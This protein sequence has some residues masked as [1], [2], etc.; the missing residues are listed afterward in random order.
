M[1][2]RKKIPGFTLAEVM[3]ALTLAVVVL[4]AALSVYIQNLRGLH[5]AEQRMKLASQ[6][7]KFTDELAVHSTRSNAFVLFKTA[8]PADFDGPNAVATSGNQDRQSIFGALRPGGDFI[9]F[10]YYQ[11]PKAVRTEAYY[12]VTKLEGYFLVPDPTT[13]IGTVRKVVIDLSAA[14][15]LPTTAALSK[16][17][18]ED[19]LTANWS[20]TFTNHTT[21]SVVTTYTRLFTYSRGLL[22][23]EHVDNAAVVAPGTARLFYMSNANNV[24]ISGQIYS[25]GDKYSGITGDWRTVTQSFNFTITPRT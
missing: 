18:V 8:T 12:R 25:T 2:L 24:I 19:I 22:V 5:T 17:A 7:K 23:P 3:V 6:V 1:N 15:Y 4:A 9:V 20:T 11:I 14:T 13:R 10:V 21:A 16:S